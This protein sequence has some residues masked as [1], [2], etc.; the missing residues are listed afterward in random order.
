MVSVML[1]LALFALLLPAMSAIAQTAGRATE[2]K[3]K[4]AFLYKFGDFVEWPPAAI[5]RPGGRFTIGVMGADDI[6]AELERVVA[7][8]TIQGRPV[9][10]RR[11]RHGDALANLHLL[12]VGRSETLRLAQIMA[13]ADGQPVL[14]VTETENALSSGSMINFV[15]VDDKVRFD[16]ALAPAERS[17]LKISSRLLGVARKVVTA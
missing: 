15:A 17:Q 8:R 10:V 2:V 11:V 12:F 13:A 3:I 5:E 14:T 7:D 6:A 9:S 16:V 1:R 4:A